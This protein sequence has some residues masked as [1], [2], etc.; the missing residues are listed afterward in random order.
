MNWKKIMNLVPSRP[1]RTTLVV[2]VFLNEKDNMLFF[3]VIV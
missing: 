1:T 2:L 3:Y